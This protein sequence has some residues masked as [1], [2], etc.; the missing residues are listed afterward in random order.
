MPKRLGAH[1][2]VLLLAIAGS[3]AIADGA[4]AL[5]GGP[6]TWVSVSTGYCLDG[7]RTGSVYGGGCNSGP[8]QLWH[9]YNPDNQGDRIMN[10]QT[11]RCLDSDFTGHAYTGYCNNGNYQ[12]WT[13]VFKGSGYEIRN[14]ATGLCLDGNAGGDIY[15][16]YCNGGNYQRWR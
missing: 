13:V 12:R 4:Q 1:L 6:W 8:Y 7:N 9:N 11:S 14:I 5:N 15:T 2:A 16:W 3:L 10:E